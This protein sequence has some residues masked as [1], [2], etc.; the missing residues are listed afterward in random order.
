MSHLSDPRMHGGR[1][2]MVGKEQQL[3]FWTSDVQY[4]LYNTA[5]LPAMPLPPPSG[6]PWIWLMSPGCILPGEGHGS[7]TICC[8]VLPP[9]LAPPSGN[10]PRTQENACDFNLVLP[11]ITGKRALWPKQHLL[12]LFLTAPGLISSK[13]STRANLFSPLPLPELSL[14]HSPSFLPN[15]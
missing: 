13:S 5:T 11:L 3:H 12:K 1:G 2:S 4:I 9:I 7:M 10:Q 6:V 8:P 14:Q 15:I